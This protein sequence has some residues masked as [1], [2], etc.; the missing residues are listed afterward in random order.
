MRRLICAA[1]AALFLGA[2][3]ALAQGNDGQADDEIVV[4]GHG[5]DA[6]Q[7]FVRNMSDSGPADQLAR[8]DQ[9][10]CS[11]IVGLEDAQAQFVNAHVA[12][13]AAIARLEQGKEG[14]RPNILIIF[15]HGA[16]PLAQG[17]VKRFPK[18][19]A[20]DG[21]GRLGLF[22][23]NDAPVRWIS[24]SDLVPSDGSP[25]MGGGD[26]PAIGRLTNS[27][28]HSSTR[29]VLNFMLVIVDSD[30]IRPVR[31][32][33]L[34]DYVAMVVIARPPMGK[35]P[36][37]QSILSLFKGAPDGVGG[38][39]GQDRAYL[40]ALYRAPEDRSAA[41]QRGTIARSMRRKAHETPAP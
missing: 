31:L 7:A 8:W 35:A 26:A 19:L 28:L 9:S 39:T 1:A 20:R 41:S 4:T 21:R 6:L 37:S 40:T 11:G 18:S 2:L 15:T 16:R 13:A 25:L 10:V 30:R 33:R 24:G 36:P 3:P 34:A 29:S 5:A 32:G 27:R 23:E 38:L 14:C 22:T 12:E 17:L